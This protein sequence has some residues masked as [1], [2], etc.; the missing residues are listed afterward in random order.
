MRFG[1]YL[2]LAQTTIDRSVTLFNLCINTLV[3]DKRSEETLSIPKGHFFLHGNQSTTC[4]SVGH[5]GVGIF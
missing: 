5:F 2:E 1:T 3:M 4:W